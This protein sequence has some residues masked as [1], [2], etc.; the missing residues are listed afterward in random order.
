MQ[1]SGPLCPFLEGKGSESSRESPACLRGY[2]GKE[3]KRYLQINTIK[4]DLKKIKQLRLDNA[5]HNKPA[6]FSG[7]WKVLVCPGVFS[8][9]LNKAEGFVLKSRFGTS[10]PSLALDFV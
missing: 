3:H 2:L 5:L 6:L 1:R 8:M 10:G 7:S 9:S 4:Q